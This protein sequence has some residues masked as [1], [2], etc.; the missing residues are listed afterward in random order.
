[1]KINSV[2]GLS[3]H[4]SSACTCLPRRS[5]EGRG[6]G[7]LLVSCTGPPGRGEALSATSAA[8]APLALFCSLHHCT[9]SFLLLF[10]PV[11]AAHQVLTRWL[12]HLPHP[13]VTT[14]CLLPPELVTASTVIQRH[15]SFQPDGQNVLDDPWGY[16]ES[17]GLISERHC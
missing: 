15:W 1:M 7:P 10:Q 12:K 17:F 5:G 6:G 14:D 16:C 8:L 3:T 2:G 9:F 13:T 4:Y 11:L